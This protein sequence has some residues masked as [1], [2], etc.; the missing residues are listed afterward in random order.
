LKQVERNGLLIAKE[1]ETKA[2]IDIFSI[3]VQLI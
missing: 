1:T 2:T 3:T